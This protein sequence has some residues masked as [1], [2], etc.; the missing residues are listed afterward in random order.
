MVNARN[1]TVVVVIAGAATA[2]LAWRQ[3]AQSLQSERY[4][5]EW[6]VAPPDSLALIQPRSILVTDRCEVW[7][8]DPAGRL[9]Y[10]W[11][12]NGSDVGR[13]GQVGGGPGEFQSP[14]S[15]G[16]YRGDTVV[17][18]DASPR[19]FRLS[20]FVD[21]GTFVRGRSLR[22]DPTARGRVDAVGVGPHG[23]L[24]WLNRIP[25]GVP[26]VN[27]DRSYVWTIDAD[28]VLRDSL[29]GMNSA[30]SIIETDAVSTSRMDAPFQRRPIVLFL[31]E[32]GF[33]VG[34]T[35]ENELVW[36]DPTGRAVMHLDLG[37]PAR[38]VSERDRA[39]FVDSARVGLLA[40]LERS[41]LG[42]RYREHFERKFEQMLRSIEFPETRQRY[43]NAAVGPTRTLW[44]ELPGGGDSYAR[45][46]H[47]YDLAT[48]R[49][50][51]AIQVP[52]QSPVRA[53]APWH[54]GLY[55]VEVTS[56]GFSRVAKYVPP[57]MPRR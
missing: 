30:E 36:Y 23:P 52:H 28:G 31:P 4:M 49:R 47:L 27:E 44:I 10:R 19:M 41:N 32:R 1:V 48:G 9:V 2:P 40:E 55:V 13:I 15:M 56:D 51:K 35:G 34:N 54:D 50:V 39:A 21:D 57:T 53:A 37:L 18:W 14:W 5:L 33:L 3:Q 8:A 25:R 46:W 29:V 17:V 43:I 6:T 38:A 22:L 11:R 7:V 45:M 26:G 42:P 12:C 24:V 20:F 16:R